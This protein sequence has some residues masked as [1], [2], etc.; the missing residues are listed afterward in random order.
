MVAIESSRVALT[1]LTQH[2]TALSASGLGLL[3][4]NKTGTDGPTMS[5]EVRPS[6]RSPEKS[7]MRPHACSDQGRQASTSPLPDPQGA[8]C[9]SGSA[10]L[11]SNRSRPRWP[12]PQLA[13][14]LSTL[15]MERYQAVV[16]HS[17]DGGI[18]TG[19]RAAG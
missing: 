16:R 10:S 6:G 2:R 7:H 13:P 4:N 9:R 12:D 18:P 19:E 5:L 11:C 8:D 15:E 14:R 3:V 17:T 1:S